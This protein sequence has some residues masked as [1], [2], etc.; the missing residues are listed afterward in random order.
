MG[1]IRNSYKIMVGKPEGRKPLGTS[2]HRWGDNIRMDF[3]EYGGMV[4]TGF[5]WLRIGTSGRPLLRFHKGWKC[6]D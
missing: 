2:M 4:W 3:R 5:I 1:K 6:I